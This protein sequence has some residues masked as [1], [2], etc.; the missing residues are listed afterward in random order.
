MNISKALN[1][2]RQVRPEA[3]QSYWSPPSAFGLQAKLQTSSHVSKRSPIPAEGL[4]TRPTPPPTGDPSPTTTVQI[5][6]EKDFS[7]ISPGNPQG[8]FVWFLQCCNLLNFFSTR[9]YIQGRGRQYIVLH[10]WL[11][12]HLFMQAQPRAVAIRRSYDGHHVSG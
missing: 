6:D 3:K 12:N 11:F 7:L 1:S 10:G 5:F 8:V 9:A 2:S 4:D